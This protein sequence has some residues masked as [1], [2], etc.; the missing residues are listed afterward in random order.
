MS[1]FVLEHAPLRAQPQKK[2]PIFSNNFAETATASVFPGSK[3]SG[4]LRNV[5]LF[6]ERFSK[7]LSHSDF[8]LTASIGNPIQ[9]ERGF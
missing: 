3:A 6:V 9:I 8:G 2:S 7:N 5:P 1:D 4:A